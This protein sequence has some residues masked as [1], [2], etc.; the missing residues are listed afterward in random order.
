ME[1]GLGALTGRPLGFTAAR[2][3]A[4]SAFLCS[5]AIRSFFEIGMAATKLAEVLE[6]REGWC[7]WWGKNLPARREMLP[8]FTRGALIWALMSRAHVTPLSTLRNMTVA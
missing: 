8:P 3:P 6:C 5:R 1:V 2:V 4:A 7:F